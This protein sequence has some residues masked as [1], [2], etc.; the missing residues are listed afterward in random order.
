MNNVFLVERVKVAPA[1]KSFEW[2]A[3]VGA[4]SNVEKA[5]QVIKE[6]KEKEDFILY[7]YEVLIL[8]D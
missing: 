5:L 1:I 3:I 7:R 8:K 4:F 2:T 6:L